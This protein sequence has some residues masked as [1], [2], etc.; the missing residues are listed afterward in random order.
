MALPSSGVLTLNDIQTE[1]G[2]TNPIDLSDYYR[3]GGLVP[4]SGLNAAIPTS[5]AISVSDFYGSANLVPLDLTVQ[6]AEVNRFP[7]T[8]NG[9]SIGTPN[10]SRM[11]V[12]QG[13]VRSGGGGGGQTP[14]TPPTSITMNG[15]EM[16]RINVSLGGAFVAWAKVPT[17]T[18]ADIVITGG[19][20]GGGTG[21]GYDTRIITFNT[22]NTTATQTAVPSAGFAAYT[23]NGSVGMIRNP[24]ATDGVF[25]WVGNSNGGGPAAPYNFISSTNPSG[26]TTTL[27]EPTAATGAPGGLSVYGGYSTCSTADSRSASYFLSNAGKGGA[28]LYG[29]FTY[30]EAN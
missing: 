15:I 29:V 16:T 6:G 12:L 4:D 24:V 7:G 19:Y 23:V 8:Y 9:V 1:F 22:I 3:G 5:G 20:T 2:G 18:T 14:Y 11:V 30:F 26:A 10:A 13:V 27:S 25:I 17:G 28:Q 21:L